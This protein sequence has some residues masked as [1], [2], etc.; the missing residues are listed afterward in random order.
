[1]L[2]FGRSLA[3]PFFSGYNS[4]LDGLYSTTFGDGMC[5]GANLWAARPPWNYD[6][7][8]AGYALALLPALAI[9][10]GSARALV[11]L[12]RRPC[13]SRI[14]LLG[15]VAGLAAAT[16]FQFVR[17]PYYAHGKAMYETSAALP[18][19]VLGGIGFDLLCRPHRF[20]AAFMAVW[21]G[22]WACTVYA[23]F[24]IN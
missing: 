20:W 14:L 19:C 24:W 9:G 5:S 11:Q 23:S 21:L 22:T 12:V 6:F 17:Y 3:D 2:R 7:M 18:V 15:I 1:L 10:L 8:A 13:S 4:V 16:V